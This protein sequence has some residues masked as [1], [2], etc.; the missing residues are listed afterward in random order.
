MKNEEMKKC[1]YCAEMIKPEAIKCRY[2]GSMLTK[3]ELNFDFLSTPGCWHRVNEG[4]KVAGVC[5]GIA[6]QLDSPVL[7]LPLRVFFIL[8]TVFYGFGIILYIILWLLM[9]APTDLPGR[10]GKSAGS[11]NTQDAVECD[12]PEGSPETGDTESPE[13]AEKNSTSMSRLPSNFASLGFVIV[14]LLFIYMF[15]LNNVM[16]IPVSTVLL[17]Y[18][19]ILAGSLLTGTVFLLHVKKLRF[20]LGKAH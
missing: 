10:K 8:T 15:V 18:T 4:K 11:V 12:E 3:K 17:F 6:R 16:R 14:L 20:P 7:I 19:F 5:T 2:C 9:P 1:P 13:P